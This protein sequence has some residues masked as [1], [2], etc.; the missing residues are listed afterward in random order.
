VPQKLVD[1]PIGARTR[2]K[3]SKEPGEDGSEGNRQENAHNDNHTEV[4]EV[5]DGEDKEG[6]GGNQLDGAILRNVLGDGQQQN[7]PFQVHEKDAHELEEEVEDDQRE[8]ST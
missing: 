1:A 2:S 6:G 7:I 5:G 3:A 4:E 8:V